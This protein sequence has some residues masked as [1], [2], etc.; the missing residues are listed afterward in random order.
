MIEKENTEIRMETKSPNVKEVMQG[1]I[2]FTQ[3]IISM[4]A[5]IAKNVTGDN[6]L[7]NAEGHDATSLIDASL[8]VYDNLKFIHASLFDI[9]KKLGVQN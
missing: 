7:E 8:I 4:V 3:E 1:N 6:I 5:D 2:N 9:I